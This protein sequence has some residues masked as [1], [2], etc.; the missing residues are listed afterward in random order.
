M[1]TDTNINIVN[2]V[3]INCRPEYPTDSTTPYTIDNIIDV[4]TRI[5]EHMSSTNTVNVNV[6][7]VGHI[8]TENRFH[9]DAI[10]DLFQKIKVI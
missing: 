5:K 10:S 1:K 3:T 9:R 4:L 6:L 2:H 7:Y 8:M